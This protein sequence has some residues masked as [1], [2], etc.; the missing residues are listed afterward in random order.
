MTTCCSGSGAAADRHFTDAIASRDLLRYREKG[1]GPTAR[2]LL[3]GLRGE[4]PLGDALLD[5]GSGIGALTFEL[6]E[7]GMKRAVLVDAS[8][9]YLKAATNEAIRRQRRDV[10]EVVHG[11][12][13]DVASG[14]R[15]ADTVTLDRVICCY[16]HFVPLLEQALRH[17]ERFFALSYPLARWYVRLG[18]AFENALR[19]LRRDPFRAFVHPPAAMERIIESA[20]FE[21]VTRKRTWMW[22]GD[23]YKRSQRTRNNAVT[24]PL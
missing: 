17:A 2:L 7:R 8:S 9:A 16:P 23:V 24:S 12:F 1:P 5:V 15:A 20:G 21:L 22:A 18:I 4:Q 10:I 6:L 11:D 13:L 3:D 19:R 14:V